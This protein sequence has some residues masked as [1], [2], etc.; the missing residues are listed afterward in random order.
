MEINLTEKEL[1]AILACII[2]TEDSISN[3]VLM[4][5]LVDKVALNK[6]SLDNLWVK[7]DN[8]KEQK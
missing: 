7:L 3:N 6:V 5:R 8:Q 2:V 1:N 4:V